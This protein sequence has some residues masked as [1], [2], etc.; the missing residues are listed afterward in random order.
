ML[1]LLTS[2]AALS[3][4]QP[5]THPP[6][7]AL[8]ERAASIT[9][10]QRQIEWQRLE[11][12]M[13]IHFGVNTFTGREWG[14]GEESPAIFNP[15]E[16]DAHQWARIAADA[17][18]KA[19]IL[20][21]KH[22]DGFCLWPSAYTE[23]SV[24]NSPWRN[25]KGDLVREVADAC[26][27]HGLKLGLYLSPA[28]LNAPTYGQSDLYN[29]YFL[30]QLREL[31]TNYGPICEVWFDGAT[32]K[33]KG[34]VYNYRAWYSLIRELQPDAAIFGKG[35]DIRWVGNE[36]GRTRA[37]EW[38]V[39]PLPVHPDD[40]HWP[41]M[42]AEDLGSLAKLR[43][44]PHLH[45]YPAE[46][47][48]S[49][50][51]GWFWRESENTK[52]RSL[53]DLLDCY[54]GAVG[55]NAVLL[56]NVP[57]D[58]RGLIHE[59]DAA[60]LRELGAVLRATFGN[61]VAGTGARS[62]ITAST[63]VDGHPAAAAIDGSPDTFWTTPDWESEPS[64]TLSLS[65]P[66]TFNT[67]MIQEHIAS[68]QRVEQ[69]AVDVWDDTRWAVGGSGWRE[70]AAG[71]TI[72]YKKLLRIPEERASRIR[73][74]L[75]DS[76][77]RPTIAELALY[78]APTRLPAPTITRDRAGQ[79]AITTP[80][81]A[82]IRY[83][84]D[85]S[86]PSSSSTPYTRPFPLPRGGIIRAQAFHADGPDLLPGAI[87]T[88]EF[89]LAKTKWTIAAVSSEQ[90]SAGEG[91]ANAIDDDPSTIWHTRYS[92]D[93][94]TH[95]HWIVIDLGEVVSLKG[96]TYTPRP[97]GSNGAVLKFEVLTAPSPD[98][99]W[100]QAAQGSLPTTTSNAT[101]PHPIPLSSPHEARYLKFVAVSER[102]NRPWAS[103]A[104]I[105]VI[106]R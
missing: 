12:T 100:T 78:Q 73:L 102:H 96:I 83:T 70:V 58:R 38:S 13:F 36:A 84:T 88:A 82:T 16:L 67:I 50:R 35:P 89:D 92:P 43:N 71:T 51:P 104:E 94:P 34:Q 80:A 97:T 95:P 68:G 57:P 79:V 14:T 8:L 18:M 5:A 63:E 60:R 91:A 46:T 27:E 45:W 30:N 39:I 54:Y 77:V 24:K 90:P 69:F 61:V 106:T 15:T 29:A 32:P 53:D 62:T 11:F 66:R 6:D 20:V 2:L 10:H 9:P 76:R 52:V 22:H 64:L 72:G 49:I 23:H 99:P 7:R 48:T 28:D 98:G 26:A 103:A 93:T 41:D 25:G 87:A 65:E 40:F 21:A 86:E 33:D 44:A 85:G 56:L 74:R 19:I 59:A 101:L 3:F 47:D 17:G 55:G 42:T 37:S 1:T 105:G 75:L 4:A 31:L 81:N